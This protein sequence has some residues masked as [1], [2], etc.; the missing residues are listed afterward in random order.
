MYLFP[1]FALPAVLTYWLAGK[2][3]LL[4]GLVWV[5]C[6]YYMCSLL[7]KSLEFIGPKRAPLDGPVQ[8]FAEAN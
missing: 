8:T 4:L 6:T 7:G 5:S 2:T 1:S 3:T